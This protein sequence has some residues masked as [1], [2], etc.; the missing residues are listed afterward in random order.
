MLLA[1]RGTTSAT[2]GSLPSVPDGAVGRVIEFALSKV[3]GPYVWG[4]SGPVAYDCSGLTQA[5]WA[6]AGVSLTHY[7]GTQYR[8]G[9][10]VALDALQ[11]GDLVFFYSINTHV[12]MYIGE[13]RFVHAANSR[14]GIRI[15]NLSG[16]YWDNLVAASRPAV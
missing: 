16:H 11:P 13:G 1:D 14:D 12:G 6:Q 8:E 7:S 9:R 3:G 2:G 10:P 15:D 5:A 4:G